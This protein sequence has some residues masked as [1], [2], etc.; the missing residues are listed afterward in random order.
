MEATLM[1][2]TSTHTHMQYLQWPQP[3][4][5]ALLLIFFPHHWYQHDFWK[6]FV[7]FSMHCHQFRVSNSWGICTS[8][9]LCSWRLS[10]WMSVLERCDMDVTWWHVQNIQELSCLTA[11]SKIRVSVGRSL[12]ITAKV[13]LVLDLTARPAAWSCQ[14]V[15]ENPRILFVSVSYYKSNTF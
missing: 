15:V 3:L 11:L 8:P 1:A 4:R 13:P 10:T 7:A 14:F 9:R 2:W 12:T 6:F 5:K